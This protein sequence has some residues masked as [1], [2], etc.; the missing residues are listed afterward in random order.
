MGWNSIQF[1]ALLLSNHKIR[2]FDQQFEYATA[3]R[4]CD[5][6][7]R[8]TSRIEIPHCHHKGITPRSSVVVGNSDRHRVRSVVCVRVFGQREAS[9]RNGAQLSHARAVS[10]VH[11][12]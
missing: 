3:L 2:A 9:L 5:T 8:W 1:F 12:R 4:Q 11:C 6:D 10:V 7:R